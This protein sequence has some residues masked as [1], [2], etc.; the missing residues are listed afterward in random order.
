[1]KFLFENELKVISMSRDIA[2]FRR[3]FQIRIQEEEKKG[4]DQ[5]QI[6]LINDGGSQYEA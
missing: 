3:Y 6:E 2:N 4:L 1:M 5:N